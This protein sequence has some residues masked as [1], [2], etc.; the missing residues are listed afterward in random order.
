MP[1]FVVRVLEQAGGVVVGGLVL[2]LLAKLG[3]L[4]AVRSVTWPRLAA[5][6]AAAVVLGLIAYGAYAVG[7]QRPRRW[8]SGAA[9]RELAEDVHERRARDQRFEQFLR[10]GSERRR[11]PVNGGEPAVEPPAGRRQASAPPDGPSAAA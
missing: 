8:W 6:D 3:G 4:D 2:A 5:I 9:W 1:R 10:D 7:L 11:R